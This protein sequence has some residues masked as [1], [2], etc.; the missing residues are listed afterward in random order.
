MGQGISGDGAG[1]ADPPHHSPIDPRL[2]QH[3]RSRNADGE[4]HAVDG[5]RERR[6]FGEALRHRVD[7]PFRKGVHYR[8]LAPELIER[9]SEAD[10]G[11]GR[12][13]AHREIGLALAEQALRCVDHALT[14]RFPPGGGGS[15]LGLA[16]R[17]LIIYIMI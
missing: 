5:V 1:G 12:K 7:T 17:H 3:S 14:D 2:L 11:F 15:R 10:S 8:R 13:V 4:Q 6:L 16:A 9:R